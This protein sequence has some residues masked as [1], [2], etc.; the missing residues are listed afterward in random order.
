MLELFELVS[1]TGNM[2]KSSFTDF[3]GCSIATM[4]LMVAGITKRDLCYDVRVDFGLNCLREMA[5]D[6]AT[7]INGVAF[8]EALQ[9]IVDEAA[10]KICDASSG[11]S[12]SDPGVSGPTTT[13]HCPESR[14][15]APVVDPMLSGASN[16]PRI[17][18][19]STT[20]RHTIVG[21]FRTS[22]GPSTLSFLDGES[23]Q[24][25][26]SAWA[27]EVAMNGNSFAMFQ[28]GD[29]NFLMELTGLDVLGV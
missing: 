21:N 22:P 9:S 6:H 18:H 23:Y 15:P 26:M 29:E 2:T 4:V 3:Q 25:D 13:I 10:T 24:Q 8:M 27:P 12:N 11:G 14:L 19:G 28:P 5:G 7:A 1:K 20:G 17:I 16:H